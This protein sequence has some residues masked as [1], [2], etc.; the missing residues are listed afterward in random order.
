METMFRYDGAVENQINKVKKMLHLSMNGVVSE[1]MSSLD[2]KLNYGVLLPRIKELA[3]ELDKS[4]PLA[5]R[6]WY[7]N[8]REMMIMATLVC[9]VE[10]MDEKEALKWVSCCHN[11]ELVEQLSLNLFRKLDFKNDLVESLLKAEDSYAKATAYV[12]AGF[13]LRGGN[14]SERAKGACDE[15]MK[16]DVYASSYVVYTAVS[17][18]LRIYAESDPASVTSFINGLDEEKGEGVALVKENVRT[19]LLY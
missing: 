18:L 1:S 11:M 10:S 3:S 17:R 4:F 2:Y 5:Q 8:C 13:L 6:L 9:P 19:V 7:S 15:S 16:S 14:L 12:L